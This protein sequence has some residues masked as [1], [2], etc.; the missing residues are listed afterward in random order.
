MLDVARLKVLAAVARHG[1]VT[2]AA[3]ELNYAQP[4]VSHHLARLEAE[5]GLRLTQKVGRGIRLTPTGD[6][7][8]QR[9]A[10]ILGRVESAEAE[11]AAIAGLRTARVRVAGFQSILSTVVA[12]TAAALHATVPDLELIL[13]DVHPTVALDQLR[14]GAVDVAVI[15]RYDDTI[16]D[17][18]R[19]QHLF[20]DPMQLVSRSAEPQTLIDHRDSPWIEGCPGC[21]QDFLNAC[22]A[23][24]FTPRIVHSSDDPVVKQALV[25]A[26]LGVTAIPELSLQSYRHPGVEAVELAGF[27]RRIYLATFGEPPSDPGTSAFVEALLA[28][29]A[30]RDLA[31]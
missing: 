7:L 9:A 25:A 14:S 2:A 15:F 11:L 26:G 27:R 4:S 16:P 30:A 20:D 23:E 13:T 19:A 24:G 12:D 29:V 21:R 22:D 31:S 6:L 8:A 1:S 5:V 17:D 28:A 18:I 3:K 10:E